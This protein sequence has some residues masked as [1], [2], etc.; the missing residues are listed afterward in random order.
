[1]LQN[2]TSYWRKFFHRFTMTGVHPT[3]RPLLFDEKNLISSHGTVIYITERQGY[4]ALLLDDGRKIF[5]L[6]LED[7]PRYLKDRLR[8][9]VTLRTYP[10]VVNFYRW[11]TVSKLLNIEPSYQAR[12]ET[13]KTSEV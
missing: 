11:G 7:H 2:V 9:F 12:P 4:F 10:K 6:N 1:M 5:A 3:R 13:K 8:V